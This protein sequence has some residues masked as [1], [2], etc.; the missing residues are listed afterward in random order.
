[1]I[2]NDTLEEMVSVI[3]DGHINFLIGSGLSSPYLSTLGNIEKLLTELECNDADKK[4]K[5]I[6]EVSIKK[7]FFDDVVL[8]NSDILSGDVNAE[9]VLINYEEFLGF[10]IKILLKRKSTLLGKQINLFTSNY[11]IFLEHSSRFP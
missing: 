11:D 6:I 9:K 2:N 1:M 7:K 3:Q 4:V 5:K 10:L 8:K